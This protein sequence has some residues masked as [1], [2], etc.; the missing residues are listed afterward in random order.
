MT[1]NFIKNRDMEFN[2]LKA[3]KLIQEIFSHPIMKNATRKDS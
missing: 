3:N 2:S 1:I